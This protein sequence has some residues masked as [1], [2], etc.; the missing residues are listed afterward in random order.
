MRVTGLTKRHDGVA[1]LDGLDLEVADGELLCVVGPSG[2]G[3]ST[4]LRLV[5]GLVVPDAGTIEVGGEDVTG[6]EPAHRGVAMVFQDL[7]LFPHLTVAENIGFGLEARGLAR[8]PARER[9]TAVAA[10]LGI[11][12]LL[13]R[14]PG[15][16]SGGER[17]RVALARGLA[18]EPAVLLLDEPL[19]SLD[20][21][22]RVTAR[23]EVRALHA[24]TGTTMVLVTHD[25]HE[26]LTLGERVAVLVGGRL[27]QV[28]TPREVYDHPATLTV[29][30]FVGAPPMNVLPPALAP[31]DGVVCGVRP[32]G[33]R[34]VE[35][36]VPARLLAVE[37]AGP[38]VVWEVAV[39][40]HVLFVRPPAGTPPPG[41]HVHL[42]V[43]PAGVR[44]FDRATGKALA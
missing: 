19:S 22:L 5:A 3:K 39:E 38:D 13:A 34:V 10:A 32:E 33:L 30:R 21:Q 11:E 36:G 35:D 43:D 12:A 44:R 9:V 28:G 40:D 14:R 29:A 6:R 8:A 26:A 4:L 7:A 31:D 15:A 20:A 1:A 42:A 23:A 37:A 17:Q 24:R 16:L 2:S 18:G 25:Q 27:E 41:E